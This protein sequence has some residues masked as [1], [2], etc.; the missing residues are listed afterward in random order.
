MVRSVKAGTVI[1]SVR[2]SDGPPFH[3]LAQY[4]KPGDCPLELAL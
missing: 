4:Q 1:I 2:G 3:K